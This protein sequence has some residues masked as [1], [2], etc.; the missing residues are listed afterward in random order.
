MRTPKVAESSPKASSAPHNNN[1]HSILRDS[2]FFSLLI[3]TKPRGAVGT[4]LQH[5]HKYLIIYIVCVCVGGSGGAAPFSVLP[6]QEGCYQ[7][8]I[9]LGGPSK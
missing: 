5:L 2:L 1:K 8:G 9:N 7:I 4:F 6:E 3:M